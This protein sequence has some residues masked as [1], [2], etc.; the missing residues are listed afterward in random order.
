ADAG[1]ASD[2]PSGA[3]S[4][5]SPAVAATRVLARA[6][7]PTSAE[8]SRDM[9]PTAVTAAISMASGTAQ[10]PRDWI[11]VFVI[12]PPSPAVPCNRESSAL[13]PLQVEL[14]DPCQDDARLDEVDRHDVQLIGVRSHPV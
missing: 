10:K 14:L 1:I 11:L 6:V 7:S 8:V 2:S 13:H 4:A 3:T 9:A 12:D 5:A